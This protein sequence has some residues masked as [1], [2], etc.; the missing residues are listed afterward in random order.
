MPDSLQQSYL[1]TH[2]GQQYIDSMREAAIKDSVK[3]LDSLT[4]IQNIQSGKQGIIYPNPTAGLLNF[5]N[6]YPSNGTAGV[7]I[8]DVSGREVIQQNFAFSPGL[9]TNAIDMGNLPNGV[10]LVQYTVNGNKKMEKVV[11]M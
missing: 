10:Y 9:Q 3:T 6:Y 11:K 8:F 1:L 4:T 2:F 5:T 7:E